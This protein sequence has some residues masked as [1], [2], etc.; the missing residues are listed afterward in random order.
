M[1]AVG[2]RRRQEDDR[3]LAFLL[4]NRHAEELAGFAC[5]DEHAL[6]LVDP[7]L[8]VEGLTGIAD[9]EN[10]GAY[11]V[12]IDDL[13]RLAVEVCSVGCVGEAGDDRFSRIE[14][15]DLGIIRLLLVG[16]AGVLVIGRG[17]VV[18]AV[19]VRRRSIIVFLVVIV[20][21]AVDIVLITV[22]VLTI[23]VVLVA[24]VVLI[25]VFVLLAA[26]VFGRLRRIVGALAVVRFVFVGGRGIFCECLHG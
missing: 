26:F 3:G 25:A 19:F 4:R 15:F 18:G 2:R 24:V 8:A 22:V 14:R 6:G 11:A 9:V 7:V 13:N 20:V 5:G 12:Q 1:Q 10:A 17:V 16:V 23:V 21:L